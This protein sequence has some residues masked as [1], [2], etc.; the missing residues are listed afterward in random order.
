MLA[1]ADG[2][3]SP[4]AW[5][6]LASAVF[7]GWFKSEYL[8]LLAS[9]VIFNYYFGIKLSRDHRSG[10]PRPSLLAVGVS[11]NLLVLAY[12]KYTNFSSETPT[13]YCIPICFATISCC[14]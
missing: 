2:S 11:V 4:I 12:F 9:L 14:H 3:G 5:L 10:R 1:R 8:A 6:V 7:Y 13:R